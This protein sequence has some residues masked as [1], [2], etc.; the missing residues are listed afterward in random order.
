MFVLFSFYKDLNKIDMTKKNHYFIFIMFV[1]F[2]ISNAQEWINVSPIIDEYCVLLGNFISEE[3]GWIIQMNLNGEPIYHTSDG[4]ETWEI[5]STEE[6]SLGAKKMLHMINENLGWLITTRGSDYQYYKTSDGCHHWEDMTIQISHLIH[7]S[8]SSFFFL[9]QDVGFIAGRDSVSYTYTI[10]KTINGGYDWY[11]TTI[12]VIVGGEYITNIF[13]INEMHGW[14]TG[15]YFASL[16]YCLYTSDGG[17]NWEILIEPGNVEFWDIHFLN[18]TKGGIAGRNSNQSVI[19]ITDNNFETIL[20]NHNI[21]DIELFASTI[22]FQNENTIWIAGEPGKVNRST[23]GG[24]SFELYQ[25]LEASGY[26]HN[27]SEQ[28]DH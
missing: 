26:V 19:L 28:L 12:P 22:C 24:E 15:S 18:N 2:T 27:K 13:F 7:E 6:D 25:I 14:A 16:G 9:N 3:E 23:N 20:F 17:E 21:Y 10:H 5:I 4:A 8:L 1:I 11:E